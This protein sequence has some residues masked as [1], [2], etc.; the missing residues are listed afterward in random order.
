VSQIPPAHVL[1][2]DPSGTRLRRYWTPDAGRRIQF[3]SDDDYAERFRE[4]LTESVRCRLRCTSP[5]GVMLS[6]G[7]DSTSIAA[8]AAPVSGHLRL[9]SFSWTFDEL[10]RCDERDRIEPVVRHLGLDAEFVPADDAW[11]LRDSSATPWD[12]G[13]PDTNAFGFLKQRLYLK[14]AR[15]GTRLLLSGAFGDN[16][17]TEHEPWLADLLAER[18]LPTA[19]WE[20]C[21]ELQ[22]LGPRRRRSWRAVRRAWS[23]LLDRARVR[24]RARPSRRPEPPDWLSTDALSRLTDEPPLPPGFD[25]AR[26][27]HQIRS[28][29]GSFSGT[30]PWAIRHANQ[31]GVEVGYPYRDRRLVEFML[32]VPAHMLYRPGQ[33]K[34]V[35][36]RAMRGL[37]PD[38]VLAQ[39]RPSTLTP[40]YERGIFGRERDRVR[41]IL[42]PPDAEWRRFVAPR[43]QDRVLAGERSPDGGS[44]LLP[45]LCV[46]FEQWRRGWAINQP[47]RQPCAGP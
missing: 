39:R 24:P 41:T 14:A 19:V 31:C 12:P 34:H 6:G 25:R 28:I 47:G 35:A 42:E 37:L 26:R 2:V 15:V 20:T 9:R 43:W 40:L 5:P 44:D 8:V 45:W 10:G 23:G 36:C 3:G 7:L 13:Q 29:L 32:A 16:L 30:Y 11:P 21:R 17:Y 22:V 33:P 27:Q 46:S 1:T 4:L 18:R 38:A